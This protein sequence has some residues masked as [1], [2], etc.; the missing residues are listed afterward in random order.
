M[1]F[2]LQRS[3]GNGVARQ[4][5]NAQL[6]G[7]FCDKECAVELS[8]MGWEWGWHS[9]SKVRKGKADQGK[10]K[11]TEGNETKIKECEGARKERKET[12]GKEK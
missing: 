10:E 7:R 12:D 1:V 3:T 6:F 5:Q 11:N 2:Y 8:L 9:N 4:S